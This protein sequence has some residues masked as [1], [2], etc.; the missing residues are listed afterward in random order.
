MDLSVCL[1]VICMIMGNSNELYKIVLYGNSQQSNY[2]LHHYG[3]HAYVTHLYVIYS[4]SVTPALAKKRFL[5]MPIK[6]FEL[7][8]TDGW[9]ECH[10]IICLQ[11][12]SLYL[13]ILWPMSSLSGHHTD[14]W[15]LP[16][17]ALKLVF[18]LLRAVFFLVICGVLVYSSYSHCCPDQSVVEEVFR[19]LT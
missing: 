5:Y 16:Q 8:D 15:S 4:V 2:V 11:P 9:I 12:V 17:G 18:P 1:S 7:Q 6:L 10:F 3:I 13:P 14:H 19:S